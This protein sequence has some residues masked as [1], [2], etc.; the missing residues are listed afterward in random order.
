MSQHLFLCNE[1]SITEKGPSY[2]V[3]SFRLDQK[4]RICANL[5]EGSFLHAKLQNGD[6]IAQDAVYHKACVSNLY[7]TASNKHLGGY[8]SDEQ[9]KLSGIAFGEQ[10]HSFKKPSKHQRMKY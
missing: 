3:Q 9:R 2:M 7:R 10:L 5:L 8:F 1:S 6:M 4:V